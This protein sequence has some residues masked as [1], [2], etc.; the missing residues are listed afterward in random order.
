VALEQVNR[1]LYTRD[2]GMALCTVACVTLRQHGDSC[3]ADVVCAGH[4]LPFLVDGDQVRTIGQPGPMLGAWEERDWVASTCALGA[5]E[6]LVLYTDGV[7]DAEGDGERFGET[8]LRNLLVG[9]RDANDA[10]Q[11]IGAALGDFEVGEQADDTAVLAVS[12]VRVA[13]RQPTEQETSPA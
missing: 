6:T 8:R 11:R 12:R 3:T 2:P 10:V 9:T 7:I 5:D 13:A 4:P 1:G